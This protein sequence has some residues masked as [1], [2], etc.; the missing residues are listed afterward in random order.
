MILDAEDK[1]V[2]AMVP[3]NRY[4]MGPRPMGLESTWPVL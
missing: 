2:S 3:R 4:S 1:P